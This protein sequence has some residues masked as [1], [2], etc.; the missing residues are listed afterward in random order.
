MTQTLTQLGQRLDALDEAVRDGLPRAAADV[1]RSEIMTDLHDWR[2]PEPGLP[3]LEEVVERVYGWQTALSAGCD[4]NST[5]LRVEL[6][7]ILDGL[8]CHAKRLQDVEQAAQPDTTLVDGPW[9]ESRGGTQDG[10]DWLLSCPT[11]QYLHLALRFQAMDGGGMYWSA[12]EYDKAGTYLGRTKAGVERWQ[13]LE[14]L[15]VM[16]A[17]STAGPAALSNGPVRDAD[18]REIRC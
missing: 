4:V 13:V 18:G 10:D 5:E 7:V 11:G 3:T 12:N 16:A 15:W 14:F 1:T 8:L 9:L 2:Y 17:E 6:S